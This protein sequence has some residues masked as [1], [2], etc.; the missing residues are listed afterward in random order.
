MNGTGLTS[1]SF[2]S[3]CATRSQR[4]HLSSTL[5]PRVDLVRPGAFVRERAP[6]LLR[7]LLL[8]LLTFRLGR[9]ARAEMAL[10][11]PA[12]RRHF[13]PERVLSVQLLLDAFCVDEVHDGMVSSAAARPYPR[14]VVVDEEVAE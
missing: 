6:E 10:H 14:G 13:M 11:E 2:S 7:R 3:L 4:P 8:K 12:V 5:S 9:L 1:R